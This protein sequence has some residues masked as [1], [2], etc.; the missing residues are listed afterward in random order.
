MSL[1]KKGFNKSLKT[2]SLKARSTERRFRIQMLT[3]IRSQ[4]SI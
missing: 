2:V 4:K 3:K 1:I